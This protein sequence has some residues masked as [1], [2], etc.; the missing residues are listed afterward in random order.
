MVLGASALAEGGLAEGGGD[1]RLLSATIL[2]LWVGACG[3]AHD[4]R[5]DGPYRL[6]A[7]DSGQ[8][9]MVC[10]D[11]SDGNCIG[12]TPTRTIGYGFNDRFISAAVKR[13]PS[14]PVEYYYVDRAADNMYLNGSEIT[15]GPFDEQQ[16][17]ALVR[18]QGLPP[19]S[20]WRR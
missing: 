10:H 18:E 1:V 20:A 12:R 16:F 7:V 15:E 11:I 2:A 5:I 17:A 8:D 6:V 9:M 3:F 13:T 14:A 4:E 19:I